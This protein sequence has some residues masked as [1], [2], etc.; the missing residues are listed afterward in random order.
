[1]FAPGAVTDRSASSDDLSDGR[2]LFNLR[3]IDNHIRCITAFYRHRAIEHIER[4]RY[5]TSGRRRYSGS[6]GRASDSS[7]VAN[8]ANR[9]NP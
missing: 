8:E 4:F 7:D 3:M 9:S 5:D 2:I 6:T 1:M